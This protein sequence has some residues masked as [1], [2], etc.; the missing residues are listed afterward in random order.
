MSFLKTAATAA[1]ALGSVAGT[2]FSMVKGVLK[3]GSGFLKSGI[4][5][6]ALGA[7]AVTLLCS[8]PGKDSGIG[9]GSLLSRLSDGFKSF[10]G[11]IG[12][13]VAAKTGGAALTA[14]AAVA[15][16]GAKVNDAIEAA[17]SDPTRGLSAR[18]V[19]IDQNF[20][21]PLL[22]ATRNDIEPEPALENTEAP[23]AEPAET[24]DDP[25]RSGSDLEFC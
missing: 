24:P 4:G 23:A 9:G 11:G 13:S 19:I 10:I 16:M 2:V 5:K 21:S 12:Q 15:D 18:D 6:L 8:D 22:A 20:E 7:G 3:V 17:E 25:E 1:S 14:T